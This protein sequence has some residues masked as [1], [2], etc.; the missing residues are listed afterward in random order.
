MLTY[1][2]LHYNITGMVEAW[3]WSS[4]DVLLHVLPLHHV[5]GV[6]NA[7]M[8]PLYCGATCIMMTKFDAEKVN[9]YRNLSVL[10]SCSDRHKFGY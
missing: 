10:T 5:H 3:E 4:Q 1:G 8:V 7:L 9:S 6:V 2:N